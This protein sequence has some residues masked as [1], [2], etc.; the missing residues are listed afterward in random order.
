MRHNSLKNSILG[1]FN[2]V[3]LSALCRKSLRNQTIVL[4]YHGVAKDQ[5]VAS[6]GNWL[7]V[8]E[9]NFRKQM[10]HLKKYYNVVSFEYALRTIDQ[11]SKKPKAVITFDDGYANNFTVAYPILKDLD[12]PA[13]IFLVTDMI[14]TNKLFWYDRLRTTL[15]GNFE[16]DKIEE[17][18]QSY[19]T[20]HPHI[21]DALVDEFICGYQL[22][23]KQHIH[24]AYGILTYRQINE[25]QNS[26]LIDFDSHTHR[27]EILTQL[28][29]GE[30]LDSIGHSLEIMRGR[31]IECGKVF[32]YP[33]GLYRPE[34]FDVLSKLGFKAA[35]S[36]IHNTWRLKDHQYEIP[37][38]GIGRDLSTPQFESLISGLWK[39]LALLTKGVKRT[40]LLSRSG[41][42]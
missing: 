37:R 12:L 39:S 32:C 17:I 38:I 16:S 2:T 13:T 22:G 30:P 6:I 25:M 1:T 21:I 19:K 7:Q 40:I 28:N 3:G 14:D 10:E 34:H 31:G 5:W 20:K 9:S 27:H 11:P 15:L 41:T 33:N 35:A 26:G 24:D 18:V 4:M 8:K 29:S 42:V 23:S 36:T